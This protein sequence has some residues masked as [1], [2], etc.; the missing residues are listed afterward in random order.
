MKNTIKIVVLGLLFFAALVYLTAPEAPIKKNKINKELNV[1]NFESKILLVEEKEVSRKD[2]FKEGEESLLIVGNHD[3]L[4]I[5]ATLKKHYTINKP[6]ILLANISSAPWFIKEWLIPSKLQELN[7]SSGMKMI[8]DKEGKFVR[9]LNLFTS[10]KQEFIVYAI[11]KQGK[12]TLQYK[13][14]VK[15]DAIDGSMSDK[16]IKEALKGIIPYSK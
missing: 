15:E 9:A 16:E 11:N 4:S 6:V 10:N 8:Y 7:A 13:G 14:F 12:I 2:L 1:N 3:S 5:I